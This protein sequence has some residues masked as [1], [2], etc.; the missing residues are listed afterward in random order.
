LFVKQKDE[1]TMDPTQTHDG[2]PADRAGEIRRVIDAVREHA[3]ELSD[4]AIIDA[5]PHL[6]PELENTL[7]QLRRVQA[8]RRAAAAAAADSL[9][10]AV[11]SATEWAAPI[12]ELA[13]SRIGP[14]KLLQLIGEGGF[15]SVFMAEQQHPVSRRVALKIIKLGMDTRSVIA[16][17]EAERQ[18]LAMMDHANIARVLDAGATDSGRPYFVM[19]L[20][21]GEPITEYCDRNKLSIAERLD[22]FTQVCNAVQHAH[23]KGIIHRDLK[24]SNVLVTTQDGKP[25]AR[26]IDFG[27]AKAT[28]S[29][30]TEKTV[31]TEFRQ[32]IGTPQYMSPEQADGSLDI[33]TRT[34]V[35]ALGVLLYELLTGSTPFDAKALR[36]AAYEEMRRMIREVEPPK[37]STRL[38]QSMLALPGVALNRRIDAGKLG[39]LVRGELDWIV[40]KALDKDRARRYDSPSTLAADIL[41]HIDGEPVLAAPPGAGY[42]LRKLLRRHRVLLATTLTI[43]TLLAGGVIAS[44]LLAMRARRAERTV[45]TQLDEVTAQKTA[46]QAANAEATAAAKKVRRQLSD[47]YVER[48]ITEWDRHEPSL[49]SLWFVRAL[50][51]D[52]GNAEREEVQRLRIGMSLFFSPRPLDVNLELEEKD[53]STRPATGNG[54]H[55]PQTSEPTDNIGRFVRMT[56]S[57]AE[58]CDPKT[59]QPL[60]PRMEHG[61]KVISCGFSPSEKLIYTVAEDNAVRFW[62]AS[63]GNPETPSLSHPE[64]PIYIN[65]NADESLA[66]TMTVKAN[67]VWETRTGKL[68]LQPFTGNADVIFSSDSKSVI[69]STAD[70]ADNLL[71][72][73]REVRTGMD[74]GEPLVIPAGYGASVEAFSHDGKVVV[75]SIASGGFC[76]WRPVEGTHTWEKGWMHNAVF[77]RDDAAVAIA[78]QDGS[79]RVWDVATGRALTPEMNHIGL[80]YADS[81]SA[82]GRFLLTRSSERCQVWDIS[83][84]RTVSAPFGHD[85]IRRADFVNG[86]DAV[87]IT[88]DDAMPGRAWDPWSHERSFS[89]AAALGFT[90][91][92][93][94]LLTYNDGA[95]T[96]LEARSAAPIAPPLLKVEHAYLTPDAKSVAI[97]RRAMSELPLNDSVQ[98]LQVADK[99]PL[100]PPMGRADPRSRAQDDISSLQFS[101]DGT[102]LFTLGW[103]FARVWNVENGKLLSEQ[104]N[105]EKDQVTQSYSDSRCGALSSD[106]RYAAAYCVN[107]SFFQVWEA[108]SNS[109]LPI[110]MKTE[111]SPEHLNFLPGTHTLVASSRDFRVTKAWTIPDGKSVPMGKAANKEAYSPDGCRVAVHGRVWDASSGQALTPILDPYP[112]SLS[113]FSRDGKWVSTGNKRGVARI[114]DSRTGRPV[115]PPLELKG[116]VFIRFAPNGKLIAVDFEGGVRFFPLEPTTIELTD[117]EMLT[118]ML[119]NRRIDQAE[120]VIALSAEERT[121]RWET[122]RKRLPDFFRPNPDPKSTEVLPSYRQDVA[123]RVAG[124]RTDQA[125]RDLAKTL[126][127]QSEAE[128]QSGLNLHTILLAEAALKLDPSQLVASENLAWAYLVTGRYDEGLAIYRKCAGRRL[129]EGDGERPFAS[130]VF[131]TITD[132]RKSGKDHPTLAKIEALIAP[133]TRPTTA[134]T[135][136]PSTQPATRPTAPTA[137][138]D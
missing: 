88:Y 134:P 55:S 65:F 31:F 70:R 40:M 1:P 67:R 112:D 15:G 8:A 64:S 136:Q 87:S 124:A 120:G 137:K 110:P 68:V 28:A 108:E 3:A 118:E 47:S 119:A 101:D 37:P 91:D 97:V 83:T 16:R 81:F 32:L 105:L 76:L 50:K 92:S 63:T 79:V 89:N 104:A 129:G 116:T 138:Q 33:D 22:L 58:L 7:K 36:S 84:G 123:A 95:L 77:S 13:G 35:Y 53:R 131:D 128:A 85:G 26:V 44:S 46:A 54:I 59:R 62:N 23:Q 132:L 69:F 86:G 45:A 122:M 14:Y 25:F 34:D 111:F 6:S 27:I 102:R 24:P 60:T 19:E 5:H 114:F 71:Y 18:A 20:V 61:A 121:E 38:S 113:E 98:V 52:Q 10:S 109:V 39:V 78:C 29:R 11:Q 130:Q 74:V 126:A 56:N 125:R 96:T 4:Q 72:H 9:A 106:G 80:T 48:G 17:F 49:A 82:D 100:S 66:A 133:T 43:I 99:H 90:A 2:E 42:R 117:L 107:G 93:R 41:R 12:Q 21:K 127:D 73:Q 75:V 135:T 115:T 94:A 57:W 103:S 51:L 30:L